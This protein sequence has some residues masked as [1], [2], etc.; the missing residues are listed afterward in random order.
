MSFY[1]WR[2]YVPVAERRQARAAKKLAKMARTANR[3]PR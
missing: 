1:S 3:S 2:P